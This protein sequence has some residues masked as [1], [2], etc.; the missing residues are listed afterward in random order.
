MELLPVFWIA[1]VVLS[2]LQTETEAEDADV[3]QDI[4]RT[5]HLFEKRSSKQGLKVEAAAVK[6]RNFQCHLYATELLSC[7][8]SFPTLQNDTHLSVYISVCSDTVQTLSH[9]LK[10]RVG[11]MNLTLS[12]HE[13]ENVILQFNVTLQ[14]EWTVYSYIYDIDEIEVL[15]P[16][17]D[18]TAS[19]SNGDLLVTWSKPMNR[20]DSLP[21]CF[22]YELDLG[23]QEEH[24]QMDTSLTYTLSNA[25]PSHTYRVK[26]RTKVSDLCTGS[27]LW[28]AWSH[29]ITLERTDKL[30]L[31]VIISIS[32]GIPMI[33]LA[34][35]LLVRH[36]RVLEVLFPPIPRPPQKYKGFL[37]KNDIANFAYPAPP[38]EPVEEITE[39]EDTDKTL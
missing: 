36:Q 16:P 12:D 6:E 24:K 14:R 23:D 25:N 30:N 11:S 10:E 27:S 5:N 33:L 18:I 7:S 26:I 2:S 13:S 35:L 1:L 4:R 20:K 19:I 21:D 32:L 28:S 34:L 37:E 31:L 17:Q 39:V 3:C 15:S 29:T 22:E 8:W 9:M 38:A